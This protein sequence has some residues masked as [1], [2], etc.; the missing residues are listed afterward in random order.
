MVKFNSI[1]HPSHYTEGRKFETIEVIEDWDLGFRLGNALKYISRA[2]RKDPSKTV[3]D[4]RKAVFYIER[5]ISSLEPSEV[6]FEL[7][8]EEV[9]EY[10][11]TP[12]ADVDDQAL[13]YWDTDDSYMFEPN[14]TAATEQDWEDF[15]IDDNISNDG[16]DDPM[17][18]CWVEVTED[19]IF[20]VISRKDLDQF[21]EDEIV[22]TI[23]KR[24]LV[25]GVKKDGSTC[26]LG[27]NGKCQEQ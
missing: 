10:L 7:V 1:D 16:Y 6:P 5:E 22:S 25:I 9:V 19:E 8:Y 23:F 26:L 2:G 15:W 3:E 17:E 27:E 11:A 13:E 20:D 18:N 21:S 4:L 24:G 14:V 12:E